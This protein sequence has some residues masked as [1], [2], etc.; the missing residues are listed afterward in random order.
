MVSRVEMTDRSAR[1]GQY[2]KHQGFAQ[3]RVR[4][5]KFTDSTAVVDRGCHRSDSDNP[6]SG[7]FDY[8]SIRIL[9][10]RFWFFNQ[11]SAD[12]D[13]LDYQCLIDLRDDCLGTG[14]A[15]G[16]FHAQERSP[17]RRLA[18]GSGNHQ[19]TEGSR[20]GGEV[21]D[22]AVSLSARADDAADKSSLQ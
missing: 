17:S 6:N 8:L 9:K 5:E 4:R 2:S 11:L 22:A 15:D 7:F 19:G 13:S 18:Q 12:D 3:D 10:D 14:I 20:G 16:W 21:Q 1:Q